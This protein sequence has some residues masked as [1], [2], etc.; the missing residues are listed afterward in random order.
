MSV[1]SATSVDLLVLNYL[2]KRRLTETGKVL[3]LEL[4]ANGMVEP[5]EAEGWSEGK[6]VDEAALLEALALDGIEPTAYSDAYAQF[7]AWVDASLDIY[8]PELSRLLYPVLIQGAIAL[9]ERGAAGE[10]HA[11]LTRHSPRFTGGGSE[12]AR[13]R[14]GEVQ[15]LLGVA[16]PEALAGSRVGQAW[17]GRRVAVAL[18]A[19]P[20]SLLLHA[21]RRPSL[22]LV[23]GL[24]S[25]HGLLAASELPLPA[26]GADEVG[27]LAD[28]FDGRA[29]VRPDA[30][31]SALLCTF[32]NTY[33][34]LA[35]A[36][37]ATDA[38]LVAGGFADGSVRLHE[39]DA[40]ADRPAAVTLRG[41]EAGVYGVS[42]SP[43]ARLV[44]SA[45]GDGTARLWSREL[46]QGLVV[47]RAAGPGALPLW[48]AAWCSATPSG[49]YFA[50]GGAD[51]AARLWSVERPNALRLFAG[52]AA[53]VARVAWM[54]NAQ[55]VAT[56]GDD[57]AAR[58]WDPRGRRLRAPL[59][60]PPRRDHGPRGLAR[61]P[62]PGP[63]PPTSRAPAPDGLLASGHADAAVRLWAPEAAG[64]QAPLAT[65][66]TKATPVIALQFSDKNLLL[67]AGGLALYRPQAV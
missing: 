39:L 59:R 46:A 53:D 43:D 8:K 6:E 3:S 60:R 38:T 9:L 45:S 65:F 27:A 24:I 54:P 58:L 28:A 30:P 4:R 40:G 34:S 13:R 29:R 57:R 20:R 55:L 64:E 16:G 32:V 44:V 62:D 5:A 51:R 7:E 35:A 12:L 1:A 22:Q 17:R 63:G 42:V 56:G 31:P 37:L 52:H 61:R 48:D 10:A 26:L 18:S 66:R 36:A 21:L 49:H 25:G 2:K 67:G 11:L 41:H 33:A 47:W 15:S 19:Y 23:L 14:A 50:T